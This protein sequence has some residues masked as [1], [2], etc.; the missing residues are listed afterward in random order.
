MAKKLDTTEYVYST[1]RFR[2]AEAKMLTSGDLFAMCDMSFADAVARLE[3]SGIVF[4]SDDSGNVNYDF[5][6]E[7]MIVDMYRLVE[8]IIPDFSTYELFRY[9]YYCH[10][11]KTEI[12][13]RIRGVPTEGLLYDFGSVEYPAPML[14]ASREAAEAYERS[15]NPQIVDFLLDKACY[16]QML[17]VATKSGCELILALVRAKIDMTNILTLIRIKNMPPAELGIARLA[18]AYIAGGELSIEWANSLFCADIKTL[19][20]ALEHTSYTRLAKAVFDFGGS[21]SQLELAADNAY[22]DI[23]REAKRISFG[24]E[25]AAGYIVAKEIEIKNIRILLSGLATGV[26]PIKIRERLREAYV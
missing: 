1:P 15:Q 4:L 8:E 11:L 7:K 18:E 9:P 6:A 19:A 13:C 14:L 21:M 2:Y 3:D 26:S 5:A 16:A 20:E 10:N 17:D 22:M 25:V 23:A 12:K 24:P